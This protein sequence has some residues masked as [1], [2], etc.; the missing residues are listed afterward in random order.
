[1]IAP[2]PELPDPEITALQEQIEGLK[3]ALEDAMKEAKKPAP[4]SPAIP[5]AYQAELDRMNAAVI[6]MR[7]NYDRQIASY[8]S[9]I[10]GLEQQFKDSRKLPARPV[11]LSDDKWLR[12]QQMTESD[13]TDRAARLAAPS[14]VF[15]SRASNK[16]KEQDEANE[17][18]EEFFGQTFPE[19]A[20]ITPPPSQ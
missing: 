6:E 17:F 7:E 13:D 18:T 10:E 3:T 15:D 4:E 19:N 8:R 9:H 11:T 20:I 14:M 5:A 1:M 2:E 16:Q 12:A